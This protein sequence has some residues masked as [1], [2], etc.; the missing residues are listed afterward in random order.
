MATENGYK[1]IFTQNKLGCFQIFGSAKRA[2][3]TLYGGGGVNV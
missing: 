1:N 2:E 3:R